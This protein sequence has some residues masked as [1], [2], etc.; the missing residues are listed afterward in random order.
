ML[1][2][3]L[4]RRVAS[5]VAIRPVIPSLA[6]EKKYSIR[7]KTELSQKYNAV[8]DQ[9]RFESLR[10]LLTRLSGY[11]GRR[12][13]K[14]KS[15]LAAKYFEPL[16]VL[17]VDWHDLKL[18]PSAHLTELLDDRLRMSPSD[19]VLVLTALAAPICG[20]VTRGEHGRDP[21][22][23]CMR[24]GVER[25]GWRCGVQG[26]RADVYFERKAP[27]SS[28]LT[29]LHRRS[30]VVERT[31][32]N[33]VVSE[34]RPQPDFAVVG[35]LK[36]E[37]MPRVWSTPQAPLFDVLLMGYE[38]RV[39]PDDPRTAPQI[40]AAA[41]EWAMYA[42][43][44]RSVVWEM[45]ELYAVERTPQP[46][47]L[48]PG[49]M[50]EP[51][52]PEDYAACFTS[53][54]RQQQQPPAG[55]TDDGGVGAIDASE[56]V[57][58]QRML[59]RPP[60]ARRGPSATATAAAAA[61]AADTIGDRDVP[62]DEEEAR[63]DQ[64]WF[65]PPQPQVFAQGI[66]D[67]LPFAP[68]LIVRSTFR[69]IAHDTA[70]AGSSLAQALVTPV[71]DIRCYVHPNAAFWWPPG[72]SDE[73]TAM[74]HIVDWAKRLPYPLPFNLYFRVDA[75][76]TLRADPAFLATRAGL[77][78][79]KHAFFDL[80]RYREVRWTTGDATGGA[81]GGGGG[82]VAGAADSSTTV[83]TV[84]RSD[85]APAAAPWEDADVNPPGWH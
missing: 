43:V 36:H 40:E 64:P 72:S 17:G 5:D 19:K 35:R 79:S 38:F 56:V 31:S 41:A 83:E 78:A 82:G 71:C 57:I 30:T 58:E 73:A 62:A 10:L 49:E 77:L 14:M 26:H 22:E 85:S 1:R 68:S 47:A 8:T 60:T 16:R 7:K 80:A 70:A 33:G 75:A 48:Q 2:F 44:V 46:L 67:A 54:R 59:S 20:V 61:A 32:E 11:V 65:L 18:M 6:Y 37:P 34:V 12:Q 55:M 39:H 76:K 3:S 53:R 45:L 25:H 63:G 29:T 42:D 69:G 74:G 21:G 4:P 15:D 51:D 9:N 28:D 50:G 81:A 13:Y 84:D 24:H 27:K 52:V 66:P 23:M